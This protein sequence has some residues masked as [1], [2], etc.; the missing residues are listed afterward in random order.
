MAKQGKKRGRPKRTEI[1]VVK[2]T[3]V[4]KVENGVGDSMMAVDPQSLIARA[5]DKNLPVEQMERLLA[6]R[7]ELKAEWAKERYFKSLAAFQRA[8]PIIGKSRQVNDKYGKQR[9]KYAPLDVIVAEVKEPLDAH[10]FSYTL[11][12]IQT[13]DSVGAICISHHVDGHS[14]ETQFAV[15]ID[16][17]AY[18]NEP[19]KVASA[20]TYASRYAFRNAFGIMTGDEDDD[21]NAC[22]SGEPPIKAPGAKKSDAPIPA[23]SEP[24]KEPTPVETA[25][26]TLNAMYKKCGASH[27]FDEDE[28]IAL[29]TI[30]A[31]MKDDLQSLTD[32]HA[33]WGIEL[34]ERSK[35]KKEK[36]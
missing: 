13:P 1:V 27:L 5:I 30:A 28:L 21:A 18:M 19:Q 33:A 23:Q 36:A 11:R 24:V 8:C 3:G 12:T 26:A 17:E 2:E 7:R 34:D 22:G 14:E 29:R 9:Y 35:A 31:A 4:A 32:L 6:M 25:R 16:H 10:G 15:P 20:L